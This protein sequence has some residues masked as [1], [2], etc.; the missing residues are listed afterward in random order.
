MEKEFWF[1]EV[2][3]DTLKL[4]FTP[5]QSRWARFE[6]NRC[7]IMEA[8]R[9]ICPELNPVKQGQFHDFRWFKSP[10]KVR[11]IPRI[12]GPH[13]SVYTRGSHREDGV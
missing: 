10:L 12:L 11:I 1:D 2:E 3:E 7:E 8:G 13:P 4:K 6:G 9:A 5:I